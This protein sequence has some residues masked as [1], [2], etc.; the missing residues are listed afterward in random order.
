MSGSSRFVNVEALLADPA[1]IPSGQIPAVLSHLSALQTT[2]T[3][4]LLEAQHSPK[5]AE[6]GDAL[7]DVDAPALY[8]ARGSRSAI[9]RTGHR[10][11]YPP[12][13]RPMR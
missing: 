11:V 6:N 7:L 1:N 5:N 3:T 12:A 8:G 4:R 10:P 9:Q 13:P 2:L